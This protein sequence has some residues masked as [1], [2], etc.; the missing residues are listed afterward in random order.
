MNIF[1]ISFSAIV[2]IISSKS[3]CKLETT[4][5]GR[6]KLNKNVANN[7]RCNYFAIWF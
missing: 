2:Q 1:S 6:K 3:S 5:K 7:N 4:I